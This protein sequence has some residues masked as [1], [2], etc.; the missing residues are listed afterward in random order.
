MTEI[1]WNVG[2]IVIM[3]IC[4][5]MDCLWKKVWMPL[6]WGMGVYILI[7]T[8]MS[9]EFSG[10]RIMTQLLPG[11]LVA[12]IL[13]TASVLTQGQIG[14]ADGIVMG[15][16]VMAAGM[17]QGICFM[18]YSLFYAF[19]VAVFLVAFLRKKRKT[20]IPFLPFLL[21]GYLTMLWQQ[22]TLS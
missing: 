18:A 4:A 13:Y 14:R 12:V 3:G 7:W 17:E 20:R 8:L 19:A 5:V 22:M 9:G 11:V 2:V 1:G 10:E 15:M 21:L 6:V 16:L